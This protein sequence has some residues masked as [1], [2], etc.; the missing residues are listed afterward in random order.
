MKWL[1]LIV[2]C[3]NATGKLSTFVSLAH[4][5]DKSFCKYLKWPTNNC[6][7]MLTIVFPFWAVNIK[8]EHVLLIFIIFICSFYISWSF[9]N[10]TWS[11]EN[12]HKFWVYPL[13]CKSQFSRF[14]NTEEVQIYWSWKSCTISGLATLSLL[15][16]IDILYLQ[17][18]HCFRLNVDALVPIH[19]W[20]FIYMLFNF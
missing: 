10:S 15:D 17:G 7:Y 6:K 8:G 3:A 1:P 13:T 12:L 14:H 19:V 11:W 18:I 20:S 16:H 9:G 4:V 2:V 5:D